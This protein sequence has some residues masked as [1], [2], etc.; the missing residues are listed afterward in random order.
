MYNVV[1]TLL[2]PEAQGPYLDIR[3]PHLAL[4]SPEEKEP[5]LIGAQVDNVFR[6]AK[7]QIGAV[8]AFSLNNPR[9]PRQCVSCG[10]DPPGTKYRWKRRICNQCAASLKLNGCVTGAGAQVQENLQVPTCYPGLVYCRGGELPPPQ[11][12]WSKVDLTNEKGKSSVKI[13]WELARVKEKFGEKSEKYD[14]MQKEDLEKLK[15]VNETRWQFGLAGIACSGARPFVSAHTNYNRCK[16]LLG[17]VFRRQD[18]A[19][20]GL[21]PYLGIWDWVDQFIPTLLPDFE[22]PEM[23]FEEWIESMPGPRKAP[24]KLAYAKYLRRG[25]LPSDAKFCAFVKEELLPGFA[26]VEGRV[27][28]LDEMIDRLIQAP[29]DITHCVAGPIL[30]PLVKKLKEVWGPESIITYGSAAPE[31]L[32]KLLCRLVD[33]QGTY[34]WCDFS[35]YDNTHSAASWRFLERLYKNQTVD[36]RKVLEFWRAPRGK[37]GPLK[38]EARVMNASGRDDTALANAIL[39][40]FATFL[41]VTAAY[42]SK[43][44]HTITVK[45]V[46]L[47]RGTIILSV[48]GDDSIGRV[49]TLDGERLKQFEYAVAENIRL[50][51]FEAKLCTSQDVKQAVYLGMRPYP[52]AKGWFWGKTIG[53]STYKMGWVLKPETRDMM[54]HITGIADMHCLCSANV[55]I[56]YDLAKKIQELRCG[57]KRTPVRLDPNRPWEWTMKSGVKYDQVTLQAVAELYT[58]TS[59]RSVSVEDVQA[60]IR[61]IE[62]IERLP[63]VID[64]DLWRTIIATDEC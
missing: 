57:A 23:S 62:S 6:A 52:S 1:K 10:K 46:E 48:C 28:Q 56:L 40:G 37:I 19:E 35:M 8:K 39:N 44:L 60:L 22:A 59:A 33:E 51:G 50:F 43:P 17:R 12:K 49:P 16:A 63:C 30:K 18:P 32:H 11:S 45:D 58:N 24:L 54:A 15:R 25:L 21:G 2:P 42:L 7:A 64:D 14:Y 3:G 36:F 47:V 13:N 9:H 5:A 53:R 61:K 38:Y 26:Q 34:F 27:E 20:W 4:S 55:P 41:S 31:T 29:A